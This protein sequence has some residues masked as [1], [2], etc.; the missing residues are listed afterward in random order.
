MTATP[1]LIAYAALLTWPIVS[2]VLY[3]LF[4]PK[5]ATIYCILGGYLL[6]PVGTF[7]KIEMIPQFDK[8][9]I[10]SLCALF[11]CIV[12][13]GRRLRL[14]RGFGIAGLLVLTVLFGPVVSSLL[15]TDDIVMGGRFL[16][17]VGLYDGVSALISQIIALIPF[18]LA[19]SLFRQENDIQLLLIA[20]TAAAAAYSIP[21]LIE[22]RISPQLHT[23]IYGYFPH[24]FAQ[25]FR[26]GGF[27][28]VVFIGHG[29]LVAFFFSTA[30]VAATS[31]GRTGGQ[32]FRVSANYV[33]IWL[34]IVLLLCKTLGA[35][36]YAIVLVPVIRLTSVATQIRFAVVLAAI[37]VTYPALRTFDFV[38]TAAI[39]DAAEL[40]SSE[41]AE[42]MRVRFDNEERLLARSHERFW[43]GWGRYGRGRVYDEYGQDITITDGYWTI[44]LNQ[45]GLIGFGAEFGLLFLSVYTAYSV[46]RRRKV[47]SL[48]SAA[49][50]LIIGVSMLDLLPNA[51]IGP[52]TWLLTGALLGSAEAARTAFQDKTKTRARPPENKT[53]PTPS[54]HAYRRQQD[55][56]HT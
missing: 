36:V 50:A 20:L 3:R 49:L 37:A 15:N 19:R 25:Q 56:S 1:N 52:W 31:L 10:P 30:L 28:P 45:F 4:Q 41:R 42:S 24:S 21:A 16:P 35:L 22:V 7:I 32:I 18:F 27:R 11:A 54:P 6:L 43:F 40:V 34:A 2:L 46:H 44:V 39:L 14:W 38:P 47:L 53:S 33:A 23:W 29:L 9:S 26:D 8:N 55:R 5:Q 17:A 13:L 51:S 48:G 12:I